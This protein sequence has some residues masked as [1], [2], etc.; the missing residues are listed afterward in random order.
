MS[1][2]VCLVDDE[3]LISSVDGIFFTIKLGETRAYI[4]IKRI[5]DVVISLL[6]N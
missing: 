2:G 5:H 3:C 1:F 4:K 6:L